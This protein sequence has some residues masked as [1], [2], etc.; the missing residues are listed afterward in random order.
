MEY[1]RAFAAAYFRREGSSL[2][3]MALDEETCDRLYVQ[4]DNCT[5]C[6]RDPDPGYYLGDCAIEGGSNS[7]HFFVLRVKNYYAGV[8]FKSLERQCKEACATGSNTTDRANFF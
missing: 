2:I 8:P 6:R 5:K 7:A 4:L 1:L 3:L